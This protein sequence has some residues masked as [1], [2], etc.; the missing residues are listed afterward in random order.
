MATALSVTTVQRL[1]TVRRSCLV[2]MPVYFVLRALLNLNMCIMAIIQVGILVYL[3]NSSYHST[4]LGESDST[5]GAEQKCEP[6]FYCHKGIRQMCSPGY[7]GGDYGEVRPIF[8][9]VYSRLN[10][11]FFYNRQNLIVQVLVHLVTTVLWVVSHPQ[12]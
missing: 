5:R 6:G 10:F 8:I 2:V 9:F 12:R 11:Y 7:W 3:D 4:V 1:R